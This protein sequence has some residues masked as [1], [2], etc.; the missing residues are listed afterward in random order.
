MSSVFITLVGLSYAAVPI[1][2]LVCQA[3]G[4]A[5]TI[6]AAPELE[7]EKMRPKR[8]QKRIKVSF[9]ADTST[10]MKWR[11]SPQQDAVHVHPGI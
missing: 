7:P 8:E 1:Y 2:R 6:K 9:N 11:F 4:L 10:S 3:T 5:G